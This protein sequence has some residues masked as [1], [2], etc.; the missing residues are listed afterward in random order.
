V[1]PS[2]AP[3]GL[4][5]GNIASVRASARFAR[6]VAR[7]SFALVATLAVLAPAC[8]SKN[9][10]SGLVAQEACHQNSECAQGLLC[11]LGACRAM[12]STA[13]DCGSGGTCVSSGA[14]AVCQYAAE[15][16]TACE[17]ESDCPAPLACA[18]DYRCRNL[19]TTAADCNVLGISG[20]VCATDANGV[21]YCAD[22][23]D[24]TNGAIT[25]AP[26]AGHGS[27]PVMEPADAT[28][29][30]GDGTTPVGD[31]TTMSTPGDGGGDADSSAPVVCD[32]PCTQGTTCVQGACAVCGGSAQPCC[33]QQGCSSGF[34]CGPDGTC[35]CGGANEACCGGSS[36]SAG[37]SCGANDAGAPICACG[38]VGTRCCPPEDAGAATCSGNA[39]CAG[40]K[41]SCIAE[42]AL[43]FYANG[44][45]ST[46]VR[47]VDGT[48]WV[49]NVTGATG[50]AY[51]QVVGD[52]ATP[53]VASAVTSG[54]NF[55][56][57][58]D[59]G[60]AVAS[61]TVWCFPLS[62]SLSDSTFLGAGLGPSDTTS[63]PVQV[64]TSIGGSPLANVQQISQNAYG[65]GGGDSGATVCAVTSDGSV[66]CWGYGAEGQLGHGDTS[67]ASY[68]RQVITGPSTPFI[69]AV[70]V[71]VGGES[72]CARKSDGSV[73]C[74][75]TNGNG[76][77]GVAPATTATSY[78]PKQVAFLG[79]AA[80]R[81]ATRLAS[82][83]VDTHCAIMQDTTVVCWGYDRYGQAGATPPAASPYA[84]GPTSVLVASGGAPLT[85][86]IDLAADEP[87]MC[88]RTSGLDVLCWGGSGSQ[89]PYAVS[90]L[91][92]SNTA[93]SGVRAP[94][95]GGGAISGGGGGFGYVDPAGRVTV[96]G[97]APTNQPPC[98]N[99]LP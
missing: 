14:V 13:A 84:V 33:D 62:G 95:A 85:N 39:V 80:Q 49:S 77:L 25:A 19:C 11:A 64:V 16:N 60:C 81:T 4:L 42:L 87:S 23:P 51:V 65:G 12:C 56:S 73:W 47:R 91:D 28:T 76:E 55:Y 31:G 50:G 67:N 90:Y 9:V 79:T 72:S 57:A 71:R 78:Y 38:A 30:S 27:D 37:L 63:S 32:P 86:V 83:P 18:S 98:T 2:R 3:E 61:G 96:N 48:V 15:N 22:P 21:L 69:N 92:S 70:E 97:S 58:N 88:A 52:A 35:A 54:Q 7:W 44:Y 26:P 46:V 99:L 89:A 74:W 94:L 43:G 82:G 1:A 45:Y 29:P 8:S 41:C 66:W 75:G 6:C 68:A 34:S 59:I 36:C 5:Q 93:V 10:A 20:R 17:K 53:L 24:V 40:S